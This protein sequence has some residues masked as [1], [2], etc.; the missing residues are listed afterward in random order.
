MRALF[1]AGPARA[2]VFSPASHSVSR[3]VR[4]G[5]AS[6]RHGSPSFSAPAPHCARRPPSA[7]PRASVTGSAPGRGGRGGRE[8]VEDVGSGIALGR[9]LWC[10]LHVMNGFEV[11]FVFHGDFERGPAGSARSSP[12]WHLT[13]PSRSGCNPRVPWAGSLSLGR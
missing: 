3:P 2:A 12:S 6:V 8:G 1:P 13:R 9:G 10:G 4:A 7:R 5:W 11:W